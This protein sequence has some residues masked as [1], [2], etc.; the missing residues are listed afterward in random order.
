MCTF[1]KLHFIEPTLA[2]FL[3]VRL[4]EIALVR[5][6]NFPKLRFPENLFSRMNICANVHLAEIAFSRKLTVFSR[7]DTCQQNVY[8]AEC[9]FPQKLIFQNERF[10]NVHFS[11]NFFSRIDTC[12]NVHL[13]E[14]TFP[15]KL[16]F[17]N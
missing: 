17:Q 10:P 13:A 15:R 3:I 5:M 16:I 11:K 7:I 4:P 6:Y 1:Q 2:I 9:T 12:Q 8:L 14:C